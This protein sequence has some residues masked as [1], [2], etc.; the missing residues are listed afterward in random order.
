MLARSRNKREITTD[1]IEENFHHRKTEVFK[2]KLQSCF[3]KNIQISGKFISHVCCSFTYYGKE[4]F[5][6]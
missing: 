5:P 4:M 1:L 2:Q 3:R 6:T